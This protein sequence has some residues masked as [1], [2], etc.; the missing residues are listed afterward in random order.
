MHVSVSP[1]ADPTLTLTS[2]SQLLD[3]V[4][5]WF[6]FRIWLQTPFSVRWDLDQY[7]SKAQRVQSWC[8]WYLT[9]HP[10]PSWLHVAGA[11]Y[12]SR[13]HDTLNILRS[14]FQY[15]KGKSHLSA[16]LSIAATH[17]M[18]SVQWNLSNTATLGTK[19]SGCN[20]Q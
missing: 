16:H 17:V 13:E 18:Y 15:L 6:A 7:S 2:L 4:E 10:A 11:L 20:T 5:D 12:R 19:E 8:E 1:P 9:N 3:S 14:Q